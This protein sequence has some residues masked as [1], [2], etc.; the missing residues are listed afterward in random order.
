MESIIVYVIIGIIY[1]VAKAMNKNKKGNTAPPK[2]RQKGAQPHPQPKHQTEQAPSK[3][4]TFEELLGEL[5]GEQSK[6]QAVPPPVEVSEIDEIELARQRKL[7]EERTRRQKQREEANRKAELHKQEV[8]RRK[9]MMAK[10]ATES[11]QDFKKPKKQK[12]EKVKK[13]FN[14]RDAIIAQT[15]LERPYLD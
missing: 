5:L 8:L 10:L 14:L 6:K 2:G 11:H 4:A 7:E 12:S 1:F 3:P 15:I 13:A 9:A